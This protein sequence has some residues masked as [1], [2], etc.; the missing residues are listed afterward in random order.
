MAPPANCLLLLYGCHEEN[1]YVMTNK[2]TIS[3]TFPIIIND[4]AEHKQAINEPIPIII[5]PIR[6]ASLYFP[7]VLF[8][9]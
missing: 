3:K 4:G 7:I 6:A 9:S 8:S 5:I 2:L 1:A